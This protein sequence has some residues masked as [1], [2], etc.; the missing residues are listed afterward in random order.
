MNVLD[1][2][3]KVVEVKVV[4]KEDAANEL[5]FDKIVDPLML[6]LTKDIIPTELDDALYLSKKEEVKQ[7][8]KELLTK[9]VDKLEEKTGLDLDGKPESV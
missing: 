7:F 4:I 3:K 6:K 5:I 1:E 2:L 9:G 8:L